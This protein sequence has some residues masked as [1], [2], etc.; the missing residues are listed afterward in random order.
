MG[1]GLVGHGTVLVRRAQQGKALHQPSS[2]WDRE[3]PSDTRCCHHIQTQHMKERSRA[4]LRPS[5]SMVS[6]RTS[7]SCPTCRRSVTLETYSVLI[8]EMCSRPSVLAPTLMNAPI[9]M[10]AICAVA[11]AGRRKYGQRACISYL[12]P[13]KTWKIHPQ[14]Q[15]IP[16]T[17]HRPGSSQVCNGGS[18]QHNEPTSVPATYHCARVRLPNLQVGDRQGPGRSLHLGPARRVSLVVAPRRLGGR[19]G[20]RGCGRGG[21]GTAADISG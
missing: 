14:E 1:P 18:H 15:S 20:R 5:G 6:T 9:L 13:D 7:T 16:R 21:S 4:N 8:W 19:G 3:S 2:A 11:R 17:P 12:A 10:M